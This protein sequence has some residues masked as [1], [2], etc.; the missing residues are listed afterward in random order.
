MR[1]NLC[2]I[3]RARFWDYGPKRADDLGRVTPHRCGQLAS[4]RSRSPA[5][6]D[7][8]LCGHPAENECTASKFVASEG[9]LC[10]CG[11]QKPGNSGFLL[12]VKPRFPALAPSRQPKTANAGSL[13]Q[14]EG[15]P[16]SAGSCW[17]AVLRQPAEVIIRGGACALRVPGALRARHDGRHRGG[18]PEAQ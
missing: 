16:A 9:N 13:S 18:R 3:G 17:L 11:R 12:R 15:E 14:R 8:A 5:T 2:L 10:H 6:S 7:A 4:L 1:G